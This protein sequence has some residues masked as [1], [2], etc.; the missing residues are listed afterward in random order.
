MSIYLED[1]ATAAS[2]PK[3]FKSKQEVMK[4][5][6]GKESGG[7]T[8]DIGGDMAVDDTEVELV[9]ITWHTCICN[10]SSCKPVFK[11][12]NS[13]KRGRGGG[14]SHCRHTSL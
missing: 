10:T 1:L 5:Y 13:E 14:G 8:N 2:C 6:T 12:D 9:N 11:K 3:T 4:T 7:D